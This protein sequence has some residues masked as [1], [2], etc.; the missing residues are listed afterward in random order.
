MLLL[1]PELSPLEL[2]PTLLLPP[3]DEPELPLDPPESPPPRETALSP[4]LVPELALR[5]AL[6]GTALAA[7]TATNAPTTNF[8]RVMGMLLTGGR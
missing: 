8:P 4:V 3:L 1:P 2:L 7:K 6:T 5:C